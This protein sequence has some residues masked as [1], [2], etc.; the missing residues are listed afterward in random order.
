[1]TCADAE[2]GDVSSKSSEISHLPLL[3]QR[4]KEEAKPAPA[5]SL[6]G[7]YSSLD[8]LALLALGTCGRCQQP[9]IAIVG[10]DSRGRPACADCA[11]ELR[12]TP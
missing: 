3:S 2:T 11:V 4:G 10:T 6:E 9:H 8:S 1:M 12:T 5:P 7:A